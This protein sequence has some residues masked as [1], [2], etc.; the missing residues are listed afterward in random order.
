MFIIKGTQIT[1]TKGDSFYCEI[2]LKRDGE[3]FT[4]A[5]GDVIRFCM[6]KNYWD[7]EAVIEKVVPNDTMILYLAP[8]DT[9]IDYGNYVYDLEITFANG[10]KDTFIN[11]GVFIIVPEVLT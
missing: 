7:A 2:S 11:R 8:E 6:K 9:S 10:D 1:L 4:P 3:A 5:E